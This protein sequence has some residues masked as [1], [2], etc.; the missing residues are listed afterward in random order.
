MWWLSG[1]H[2]RELAGPAAQ[3]L[4]LVKYR[5][6]PQDFIKMMLC[7]SLLLLGLKQAPGSPETAHASEP[8][9]P[10]CAHQRWY[11]TPRWHVVIPCVP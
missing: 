11:H 9:L 8:I 4:E 10:A 7:T 6:E 5:W 1:L 3:V 2:L